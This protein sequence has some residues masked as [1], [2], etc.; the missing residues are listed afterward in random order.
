V[1]HTRTR[2]RIDPRAVSNE[3][4][5][6]DY[7]APPPKKGMSPWLIAGL[8]GLGSTCLCCGGLIAWG[9]V[10]GSQL[11]QEAQASMVE[12]TALVARISTEFHEPTVTP[13]INRTANVGQPTQ[14]VFTVSL[15]NSPVAGTD[16]VG[17]TSHAVDIARFVRANAPADWGITRICVEYRDNATGAGGVV[18]SSQNAYCYMIAELDAIPAMPAPAPEPT[19]EAPVAPSPEPTTPQP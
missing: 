2:G 6:V 14:T 5:T 13:G 7:D 9:F 19:P 15:T 17:R 3:E 18:T 16:P 11:V 4:Q 10:G 8:I 12:M 1:Q